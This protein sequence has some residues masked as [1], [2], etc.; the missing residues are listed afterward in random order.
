[1]D[2]TLCFSAL[3]LGFLGSF[4][5]AGMC[6]P[7]VLMLPGNNQSPAKAIKGK[8]IYNTGRIFTYA[9]IGLLSGSLG[10]AIAFKGFQKELSI[11]TGILIIVTIIITMMNK[12]RLN[13]YR[14]TAAFTTPLRKVLKKLYSQKTVT[15]FFLIGMLNGLLPCG[16]VYLALAGAATTASVSGGMVYMLL[17]GLGTFPM[18]MTLTMAVNFLGARFAGLYSRISPYIAIGLAIFLIVRGAEMKDGH[19]CHNSAIVAEMPTP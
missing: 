14:I 10:L 16:F 18:M 11:L 15:S 19:S 3:A 9:T 4:H 7:L 6:G 2:A 13:S 8:L 5:C 1:M 17:F 12:N